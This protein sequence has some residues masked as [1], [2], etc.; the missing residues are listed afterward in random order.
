[1]SRLVDRAARVIASQPS[2]AQ[3]S[4]W[5]CDRLVGEAAAAQVVE[6]R[7]ADRGWPSGP[8]G[9]RRSPLRGRRAGACAGRPRGVVR[10]SSSTPARAARRLSASG[11]SHAVALHDEAEDVAAQAAAEALPALAGRRDDEGR[12]LLAVE[13]AEPLEGRARLLELDG[14]ADDVDEIDLVLDGCSDACGRAGVPLGGARAVV[15][16]RPYPRQEP[17]TLRAVSS[18]DTA[19]RG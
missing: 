14:L 13:R 3:P 8:R 1:M 19:S 4:W 16:C 18:L 10:S 15:R 6:R 11:N 7:L 2:G 12:R 9:R 5:A 17:D